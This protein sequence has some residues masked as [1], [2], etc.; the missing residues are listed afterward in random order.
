MNNRMMLPIELTKI[1]YD[2]FEGEIST[3][4]Q[5]SEIYGKCL[6]GPGKVVF[7]NGNRYEGEFYNGLLNGAGRFIWAN[8]IVYEGQ[9]TDNRITGRGGAK[10]SKYGLRLFRQVDAYPFARGD[11]QRGEQFE[12]PIDDMGCGGGDAMRGEEGGALAGFW[13]GIADPHASS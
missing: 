10:Q 8:G 7:K 4:S 9:F 5:D 11:T 2:K 12:M 3:S 13:S 6:N 1:L